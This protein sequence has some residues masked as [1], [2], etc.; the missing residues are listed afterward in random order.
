VA[1]VGGDWREEMQSGV[2]CGRAVRDGE[3][4]RKEKSGFALTWPD[5]G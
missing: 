5:R 2:E 4:N 1:Q 3:A